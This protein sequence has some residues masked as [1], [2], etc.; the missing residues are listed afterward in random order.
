[1]PAR[2][3]ETPT[4][5]TANRPKVSILAP[6]GMAEFALT[7]RSFTRINGEEPTIVMVPP[8]IAQVP[9]GMRSRLRGRS[10]RGDTAHHGQ[11]ESGSAHVLNER[12]NHTYRARDDGDDP[13][14]ARAAILQD[15]AR[16]PAHEA[17][18]VEPGTEDHHRDDGGHRIRGEAAKQT[19][20]IGNVS[21]AGQ[22]REQ[23]QGDHDNDRREVD[24][25]HLG[26]EQQDGDP[27]HGK[28][29]QHFGGQLDSRHCPDLSSAGLFEVLGDCPP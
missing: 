14:L 26:D 6:T 15:D 24:P 9:I 22:L 4:G 7:I 13:R 19:V 17:G 23:T 1:M 11:K 21:E 3:S 2:T 16:D 25:A 28:D 20:G 18:L 29:H 8:R 10:V 12:E 27:E 5:V